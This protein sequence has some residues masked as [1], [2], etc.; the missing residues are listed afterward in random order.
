MLVEPLAFLLQIPDC[1]HAQFDGRG[2][3]GEDDLLRDKLVEFLGLQ[4]GASLFST[5]REMAF[6]DVIGQL[7]LTVHC[8]NPAST[9]TAIDQSG[10]QGFATAR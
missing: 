5:L 9:A 1:P 3:Q 6:A 4:P 2:L 7:A 8:P 10:E